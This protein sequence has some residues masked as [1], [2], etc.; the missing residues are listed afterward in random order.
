MPKC[1][2]G[3]RLGWAGDLFGRRCSTSEVATATGRDRRYGKAR[4]VCLDLARPK[5]EFGRRL[6][7]QPALVEGDALVLPF[8]AE[9]FDVLLSVC[10]PKTQHATAVDVKP[11]DQGYRRE[12]STAA[13]RL[14]GLAP[15]ALS[16]S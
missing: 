4:A 15:E 3:T 2:G 13:G 7:N 6:R 11:L 1:G 10:A 9:S 14:F 12:S 16:D 8:A 5:L